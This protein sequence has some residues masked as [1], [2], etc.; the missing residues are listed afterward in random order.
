MISGIQPCKA[1]SQSLYMKVAPS[2][3]FIIHAGDLDLASCGGFYIFR[4]LYYIIVIEIS[5]GT[6]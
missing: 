4:N 3:I 5:P 6:A 2:E 1:S